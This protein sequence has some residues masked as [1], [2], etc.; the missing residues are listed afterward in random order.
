MSDHSLLLRPSW[1]PCLLMV[2]S[3]VL[4]LVRLVFLLVLCWFVVFFCVR[5][6]L[7]FFCVLSPVCVLSLLCVV[8][9]LCCVCC[10][11]RVFF[12][13]FLKKPLLLAESWLVCLMDYASF[14]MMSFTVRSIRAV[15]SS[16]V[17]VFMLSVGSTRSCS[18]SFRSRSLFRSLVAR[19]CAS[20]S[21]SCRALW[22]WFMHSSSVGSPPFSFVRSAVFTGTPSVFVTNLIFRVVSCGL[23]WLSHWMV[24]TR[25]SPCSPVMVLHRVR[26][27]ESHSGV[28]V[29]FI[30]L[31]V[32]C[33]DLGFCPLVLSLSY[34]FRVLFVVFFV[35]LC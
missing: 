8:F 2:G 3:V 16:S 20:S 10:R 1:R 24:A 11:G 6:F 19:S 4:L 29:V 14:F 13:L 34:L 5:V 31:L 17:F 26:V 15:L 18:C 9:C 27:A 28:T 23:L 33:K 22:S 32:S 21:I 12:F 7:C 25:C 35:F 30:L